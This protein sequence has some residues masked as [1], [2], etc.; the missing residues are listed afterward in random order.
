M[1]IPHK[2]QAS[3]KKSSWKKKRAKA[4]APQ[5][6]VELVQAGEAAEEPAAPQ[7]HVAV[8]VVSL[9]ALFTLTSIYVAQ[10]WRAS[11]DDSLGL[12]FS[13]PQKNTSANLR[14]KLSL[15]YG[16]VAVTTM[17]APSGAILEST[18][19]DGLLQ[20]QD[21][22]QPVPVTAIPR[23]ISQARIS[24]SAAGTQTRLRLVH[25][26]SRQPGN[27][28][29]PRVL[30][31]H[32]HG[33]GGTTICDMARSQGEKIPR[34]Q[35]NCNVMPDLCSTP[36]I[37]RTPCTKRAS[38]LQYTFTAIERAVDEDD[39]SCSGGA[40]SSPGPTMLYGAM[41][42][43]PLSGIKS[44]WIGNELEK[45]LILSAIKT[46]TRPRNFQYHFCLPPSDTYQHFDNFAV[47]TLSGDYDVAPGE[48]TSRHLERAKEVLSRL[49]VLLI[50]EHLVDHLPQLHAV[51][52]WDLVDNPWR[53]HRH[54]IP[55]N[56]MSPEEEIFLKKVNAWDY[57]LYEFGKELALERTA[58]AKLRLL[59]S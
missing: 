50:L 30:W 58:Q 15:T 53:S 46:K 48:V 59:P 47:R 18:R 39:L 27:F 57:E 23:V 12:V 17:G 38:S 34:A 20:V 37:F 36:K 4:T 35:D 11:P 31:L 52:G 43:D 24:P 54:R 56:A 10:F 2:L 9:S 44:T 14:D 29:Q 19:Y 8:A 26:S 40:A 6:D 32:L 45:D 42:R 28:R 41:L 49:D 33:Y 7:R 13:G 5:V 3:K 51:F 25:M 55:K 16:G 21:S 1:R 22:Q